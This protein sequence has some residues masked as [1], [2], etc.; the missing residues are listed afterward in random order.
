MS[1]LLPRR[2]LPVRSPLD[3]RGLWRAAWHALRGAVDE[4][5]EAR[6]AARV[7]GVSGAAPV[8]ALTDSG[9]TALVLALRATVPPG[10]TVALPGYGC[11]D[12]VAAAIAARVRVR[13][14]DVDPRTLG[15]D[16][17]SLES[18]LRR[19]VDA[20]VVAHAYGV[21]ADVDAVVALAGAAGLPV[22][23]DAAQAA[24]ALLRGRPLGARAALGVLSFGRGKGTTAGSGGALVAGAPAWADRVRAIVA[25]L[26]PGGSG[27][28]TI[29]KTGAQWALG[30]PS[31]YAV[32]LAIPWLRLGEMVYHPAGEP[33][34]MA[35]GARALLARALELDDA[36]V[37]HRRATA[38][39]LM[40]VAES[41]GDL[42]V[43]RPPAPATPGWLRFPVVDVAG[44]RVARPEFGIVRGYPAPLEAQEPAQAVLHP[45]EPTTPGAAQLCRALFTLP[46]HAM[47]GLRD[48]AGLQAWLRAGTATRVALPAA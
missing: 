26:P 28:A 41:A 29:A 5:V 38:G 8:V 14:Y 23:E 22:I 12:L 10:G 27:V 25:T 15:P 30:R 37:A 17:T 11:V 13:L 19:G 3:A 31:V 48:L 6:V 43:P 40:E 24:G 39:A 16:L 34:A 44:T 46:T 4:T 45:G 33:R 36:E 42:L 7:G 21:P 9:T 1:A 47:V 2:Q 32:P 18:A 20:V 35:A